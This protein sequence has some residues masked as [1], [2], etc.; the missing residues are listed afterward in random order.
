M[1]LT[2]V[3]NPPTPQSKISWGV[4]GTGS[5]ARQFTAELR[6][7]ETATVT[8]VASRNPENALKFSSDISDE[9]VKMKAYKSFSEVFTDPGVDV[10]YI[11]TPTHTHAD[12]C[13]MALQSGKSVLC[14]KPFCRNESEASEVFS[15]AR[16]RGLFA[17]EAMWMRFNPLIQ[18]TK[19]LIESQS[20]GDVRTMKVDLGYAKPL[21]ALDSAKNGKG[22]PLAFG[23]YGVSLSTYLFGVPTS[24]SV[25]L[26][27]NEVGA[28]E[29][30][31][32]TLKYPSLVVSIQVSEWATLGNT[33]K[34]YGRNGKISIGDPFINATCLHVVDINELHSRPLTKRIKQRTSRVLQTLG[35]LRDPSCFPE[36][37]N[38][39]FLGEAEEVMR[40]MRAGL[41]ESPIMPH[42]HTLLSHR[43]I[44]QTPD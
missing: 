43:L 10:V 24:S 25:H 19:S 27:T 7:S 9:Q 42:E 44:A 37:L 8:G 38:A 35:I 39:G 5:I 6:K 2:S 23:C 34:I 21:D 29:T 17:M 28:E 22:A 31:A 11:S 16:S 26:V 14:E 40:C 41:S 20:I 13:K 4:L 12:L 33:V 18:K 3:T 32:I 15:L 1:N 36:Y 30:A